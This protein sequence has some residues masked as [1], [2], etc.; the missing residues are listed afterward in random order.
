VIRP[1]L[2]PEPNTSR[3]RINE[4]NVRAASQRL[5]RQVH[6]SGHVQGVGFRYTARRIAAG[7]PIGGYVR[8][9]PDGRV[10]LVAEGAADDVRVFLNEVQSTLGRHIIA[11][12]VH[13]GPAT[14]EFDGFE[15][16]V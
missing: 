14:D 15:I 8:N 12:D 16:R 3:Q 7:H 10:L 11:A 13:D 9:L 4:A 6:F 2:T 5:R 1:G